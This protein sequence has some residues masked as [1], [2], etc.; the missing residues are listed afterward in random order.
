[1]LDLSFLADHPVDQAM[2]W[3]RELPGVGAHA[4]AKTLCF[5]TLNRRALPV[6][7]H[8]HRVSRRL[9]LTDRTGDAAQ[10]FEALM[11]HAPGAWGPEDMFE[12]HWLLKALGQS[13]CTDAHPRCGMCPL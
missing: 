6:D 10:A 9:G 1:G 4:A 7:G 2:A 12:T 13:V 11:A 5:S 8:V 3:L